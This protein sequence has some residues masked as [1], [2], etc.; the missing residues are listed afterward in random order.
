[1][2][3]PN[4]PPNPNPNPEDEPPEP[5][6]MLPAPK[7]ENSGQPDDD[8]TGGGA[9]GTLEVLSPAQRAK[10]LACETVIESGWATFVQVGFA[11]ATIKE[12]DLFREQYGSFEQ[13]CR[14]KWQYSERYANHLISAAQ[15]FRHLSANCSEHKPCHEAQVRP[16]TGLT[17]EQAQ[18]AWELAVK[19]AAGRRIT[20]RAV[21]KAIHELQIAP[22]PA[23]RPVSPSPSKSELRQLIDAAFVDLMTLLQ[24]KAAHEALVQK[25]QFLHQQVQPL[26]GKRK[27]KA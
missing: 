9:L 13:Y 8:P 14:E 12:N 11:L 22:P 10:L 19:T 20:A 21:R 17:P 15:V 24:Q 23:P 18:A 5:S 7:P 3:T 25:V 6:N 2:D 4:T 16:L 26:L 27:G 1:M